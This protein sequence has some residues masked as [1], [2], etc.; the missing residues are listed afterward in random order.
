MILAQAVR[1]R[2]VGRRPRLDIDKGLA[3][4]RHVVRIDDGDVV[5]RDGGVDLVGEA[6]QSPG[7]SGVIFEA[8]TLEVRIERREVK[9]IASEQLPVLPIEQANRIRCV[10]RRSW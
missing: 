3:Q 2:H 7:S 8:R 6:R 1:D 5:G 9:R 10:T 4:R